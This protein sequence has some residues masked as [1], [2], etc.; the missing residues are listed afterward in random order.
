M[1]EGE[2]LMI[3][4][5]KTFLLQSLTLE[6]FVHLFQTLIL[7]KIITQIVLTKQKFYIIHLILKLNLVKSIIARIFFVHIIIIW[8]RNHSL[9]LNLKNL[10]NKNCNLWIQKK[11]INNFIK[12]ILKKIIRNRIIIKMSQNKSQYLKY[13]SKMILMMKMKIRKMK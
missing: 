11:K 7:F 9:K 10:E 3:Y 1:T 12:W 4:M 13:R 2:K 8:M 5:G 6:I